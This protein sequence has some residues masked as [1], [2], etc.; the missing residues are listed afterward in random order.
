M[1]QA[2]TGAGIAIPIPGLKPCP[3]CGGPAELH[4]ARS[5]RRRPS[6][7]ICASCETAGSEAP[8]GKKAVAAWNTRAGETALL[9]VARQQHEALR[10]YVVQG[11]PVRNGAE[12][13]SLWQE[14]V[15]AWK[16]AQA[17]LAAG[18]TIGLEDA[19]AKV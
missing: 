8:T 9:T 7:V 11:E 10:K 18:A 15:R 17:A 6:I 1:T 19:H 4:S 16:E 5:D 13:W 2:D 12:L 14:R 3:F